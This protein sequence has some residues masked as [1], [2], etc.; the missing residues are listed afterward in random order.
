MEGEGKTG[1][2][3]LAEANYTIIGL[4]N[5][6]VPL[7]SMQNYIHDLVINHSG[8]YMYITESLFCIAEINTL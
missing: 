4:I 8:K 2:L 5:R 3:G 1:S 7:Y 6:K